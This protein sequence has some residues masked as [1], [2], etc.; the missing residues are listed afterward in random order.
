[1]NSQ[2]K[3]WGQML[4]LS[5]QHLHTSLQELAYHNMVEN[6]LSPRPDWCKLSNADEFASLMVY[7]FCRLLAWCT[8]TTTAHWQFTCHQQR[9]QT[10]LQPI[11]TGCLLHQMR[12]SSSFCG[13]MD[14]TSW[15][16]TISTLL[17]QWSKS[18]VDQAQQLQDE[19]DKRENML[20]KPASANEC[21]WEFSWSYLA[22]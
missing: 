11:L 3:P 12:H 7:L 16:R 22:L 15:L 18:P 10:A 20:L 5:I 14:P 8:A 2:E 19:S 4:V 9:L 1:M 21:R 17:H 13:S 6:S